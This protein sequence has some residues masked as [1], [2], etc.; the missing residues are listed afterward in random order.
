MP[1]AYF[2]APRLSG[3]SLRQYCFMHLIRGALIRRGHGY[4]MSCRECGIL[5]T[6]TDRECRTQRTICQRRRTRKFAQPQACQA[7][8]ERCLS[9]RSSRDIGPADLARWRGSCSFAPRGPQSPVS[10]APC[11]RSAEAPVGPPLHL[12][13][14]G[15]PLRSCSA[16]S[17]AALLSTIWLVRA[18]RQSRNRKPRDP[19]RA[20]ATPTSA[21]PAT[22]R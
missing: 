10:P 3:D 6:E 2:L 9:S 4:G 20:F 1:A 5:R 21:F 7:S 12:S 22:R 15:Q 16:S 14:N 17:R 8:A 13:R 18:A 11:S 19:H